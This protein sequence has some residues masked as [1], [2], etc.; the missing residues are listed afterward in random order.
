M[1]NLHKLLDLN[2]DHN[3]AGCHRCVHYWTMRINRLHQMSQVEH[4]LMVLYGCIHTVW[5]SVIIIPPLQ[6]SWKGGILV[7]SCLSICPSICGWDR[8]HSVS[9][10]ILAGFIS[11]L[12]ILSTIFRQCVACYNFGKILKFEVLANLKKNYFDFA[13]CPCMEAKGY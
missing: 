5:P 13:L 1:C 10:T 6:R 2:R 7:S 3:R 4:I 9:S 12:H 11:Y 8:V